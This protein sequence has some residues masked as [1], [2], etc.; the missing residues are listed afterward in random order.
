MVQTEEIQFTN[1][2]FFLLVYVPELVLCGSDEHQHQHK[3][4]AGRQAGLIYQ[5]ITALGMLRG[6][7]WPQ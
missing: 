1:P 2:A 4:E 6:M 5:G 3:R 7:F